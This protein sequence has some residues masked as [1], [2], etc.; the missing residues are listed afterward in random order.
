LGGHRS[1][2]KRS[3]RSFKTIFHRG[4]AVLQLQIEQGAKSNYKI[5]NI[6]KA[7]EEFKETL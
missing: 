3:G 6:S 5:D 7:F 4:K 2:Q 1:E